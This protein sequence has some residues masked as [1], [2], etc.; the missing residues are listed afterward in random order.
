MNK[1]K[2]RVQDRFNEK[3]SKKKNLIHIIF[4]YASKGNHLAKSG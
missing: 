2:P 1:S 3:F 4:G